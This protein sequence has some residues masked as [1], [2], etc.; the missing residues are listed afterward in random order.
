MPVKHT[1][2]VPDPNGGWNIKQDN[3]QRASRHTETIAAKHRE[4]GGL[5][6]LLLVSV[7][8]EN[9]E[10]VDVF[11]LDPLRWFLHSPPNRRS[12]VKCVLPMPADEKNPTSYML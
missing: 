9:L 3:A 8:L 1:H 2:V 11:R 5:Q 6:I 7:C 10:P 12:I 4:A